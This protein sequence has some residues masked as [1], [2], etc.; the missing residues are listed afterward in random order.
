MH[1]GQKKQSEFAE[2]FEFPVDGGE[3]ITWDMNEAMDMAIKGQQSQF[4]SLDAKIARAR[5]IRK[6]KAEERREKQ[7]APDNA[8]DGE[9]DEEEMDDSESEVAEDAETKDKTSFFDESIPQVSDVDF[10]DMNLSRPLLKAINGLGFS[11]PTPIQANTIPVALLGKDIC[12]CAATGT[13]KTAAF[14]LPILERLLYRP[15]NVK[16]T[17]V[18]VVVPT[19]ELAIQVF[20]VSKALSKHTK[21][22]ICLAAGGLE[23]KGQEAALRKNPDIVIATPG[24][25]VDHLRNTPCFSLQNIE[26]LV[27]DEA[28]RMLDE[29]FADQMNE[30]IQACPKKRQTMLFS[31]TMTD[32]VQDLVRL[33]LNHPVRVFVDSNTDTASNLSQEFVRI[34]SKKEDEREAIVAALCCRTFSDHCLVFLPTKK[35]A[36]RLRVILGLLGKKAA[37]LHGS[38]SQ[39][40]RMEALKQFKESEADFLLATDL[41]ARGL[42]IE[43]V[44]TVINFAMPA[45]VKQYIHRVGR[46]ARAGRSGRSITLVGEKERKMLKDVVKSAKCPVKSRVI[47]TEVIVRYRDKIKKLESEIHEILKA[48]EEEKQLRISEMEVK[49][50]C[51]MIEH[52]DEIFS[53]PARTWIQKTAGT[54]RPSET[55]LISQQP[56]SKKAKHQKAR[57]DEQP[58]DKAARLEMEYHARVAKRERKNKKMYVVAP[59]QKSKPKKG[60]LQKR[61]VIKAF[62]REL[63]DTTNKALKEFRSSAKK[64]SVGGKK[65]G[66]GNKFNGGKKL[67]GGKFGGTGKRFTGSKKTPGKKKGK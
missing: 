9:Q 4:T 63:T 46:T 27:L 49:K 21:V 53:R 24:R 45:T 20:S 1:K 15:T 59:V 5:E 38:L 42:D 14:M 67:K 41:A 60:K 61:P 17:R 36:H 44:K 3:R 7:V 19:R 8:S 66:G 25:L 58:E 43:R 47:S 33:S 48:E 40:Q 11:S 31:A 55:Q 52:Q 50:A 18:L 32:Q 6:L 56:A 34:K 64:G 23:N 29:H 22:E 26:I 2:S 51:N 10:T 65:S 16:V 35:L 28:D 54:K 39:M 62:D 12:A 37:E 13:G 30:I 57:K